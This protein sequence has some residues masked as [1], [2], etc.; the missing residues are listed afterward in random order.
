MPRTTHVSCDLQAATRAG[1]FIT[2]ARLPT[3]SS[4][5]NDP[6][7]DYPRVVKVIDLDVPVADPDRDTMDYGVEILSRG[8]PDSVS[9]YIGQNNTDS[10]TDACLRCA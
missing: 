5:D 1:L 6:F 8:F 4:A 10:E 7:E 9:V 2:T 3:R